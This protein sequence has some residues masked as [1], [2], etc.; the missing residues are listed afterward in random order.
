MSLK[1]GPSSEP[2]HICAKWSTPERQPRTQ[3]SSSG[4]VVTYFYGF[5]NA[6]LGRAYQAQVI[7]IPEI[8]N[9]AHPEARNPTV[10]R[11]CCKAKLNPELLAPKP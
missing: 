5:T 9:G 3:V 6:D 11:R 1:Y 2:L 4:A 8:M 10:K 7:V